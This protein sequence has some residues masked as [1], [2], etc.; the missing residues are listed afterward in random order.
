MAEQ[1]KPE[2]ISE[3]VLTKK[4][5][6][7]RGMG[8]ETLKKM[9]VR[10]SS[11]FLTSRTRRT[12]LRNF[13]VIEKFIK[14]CEKK[15]SRNKKIRTHQRDIIIVPHMVGLAIGIHNGKT[16]EEVKITHEMIGHRLG[17]FAPTRSK[18]AH[19]AAGIGATK[20]SKA[21]KK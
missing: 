5:S 8:I 15:M 2:E 10:E 18:V 16:F 3:E 11:K 19:S 6:T 4:E 13:N 20:S 9:D 21:L 12:I 1:N 7:Y 17:E 14:R